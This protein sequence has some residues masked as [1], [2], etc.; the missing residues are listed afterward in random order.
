[1]SKRFNICFEE[2]QE[3][4]LENNQTPEE[5]ELEHQRL[6]LELDEDSKEINY[7]SELVEGLE[8]LRLIASKL[9]N[10][11]PVE[12]ALFRVAANMAVAGKEQSAQNFLP[13]MESNKPIA[14][15]GFGT[16]IMDVIK[17]IIAKLKQWWNNFVNWVKGLFR[18]EEKVKLEIKEVKINIS[19]ILKKSWKPTHE[20]IVLT[21]KKA[22]VQDD[23]KVPSADLNNTTTLVKKQIELHKK[24][25]DELSKL[26]SNNNKVSKTIDVSVDKL[27]LS[28]YSVENKKISLESIN[29]TVQSI[30]ELSETAMENIVPAYIKHTGSMLKILKNNL[31]N[32]ESLFKIINQLPKSA[33]STFKDQVERSRYFIVNKDHQ[34][35]LDDSFGISIYSHFDSTNR[36]KPFVIRQEYDTALNQQ[37]ITCEQVLADIGGLSKEFDTKDINNISKNLSSKIQ[38]N[39]KEIE[40]INKE[41]ESFALHL[42]EEIKNDPNSII[43]EHDIMKI[44]DLSILLNNVQ[45]FSTNVFDL[46]I[47]TLHCKVKLYNKITTYYI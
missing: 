17:A 44:T 7:Q 45:K 32:K 3:V 36:T 6:A 9:D 40:K 42:A 27:L 20:K 15:E 35:I 16:K 12:V 18:K 38:D 47:E 30:D 11:T 31:N 37:V 1:M 28:K 39:S 25:N 13:A 29:R 43:K 10:P 34:D 19:E 26:T 8:S 21:T 4:P 2:V 24:V 41:I 23:N 5:L 22:E 46:Y 33:E 14:L